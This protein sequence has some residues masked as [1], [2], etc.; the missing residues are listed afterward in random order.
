MCHF[1]NVRKNAKNTEGV[2]FL[3]QKPFISLF[4]KGRKRLLS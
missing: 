4:F 3:Q 1:Q 2:S